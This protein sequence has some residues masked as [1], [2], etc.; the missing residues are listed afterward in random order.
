MT[1]PGGL[2]APMLNI[3]SGPILVDAADFDGTNDYAARGANL[4]NASDSKIMTFV[5]WAKADS[6]ASGMYFSNATAAGGGTTRGEIKI[7]GGLFDFQFRNSAGT[8]ILRINTTTAPSTTAWQCL[9]CSVDLADTGKRHLYLGDTDELNVTTYTDDSMDFTVGDWAVGARPDGAT[10]YNG[11]LAEMLF[12]A[13]A[14]I[15]FSVEASRR[16]FITAT[17]KPVNPTAAISSLGV[18]DVYFHLDKGETANN[19]VANNEQGADG[20][21][22]TVTGELSTYPSSPSD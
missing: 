1:I 9:M 5:M 16:L 15:D 14:Y 3:D 4:T 22:F 18:P 17:G 12:W 13:G 6:I 8:N 2:V 21:E 7:S 10:K 19:F 11:G 20:G